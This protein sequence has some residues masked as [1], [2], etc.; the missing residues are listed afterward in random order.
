[1]KMGAKGVRVLLSGRLG[2]AEMSRKYTDRE[3]KIPLQTLRADI[4]YGFTEARTASGHIGVKVWIYR[5][6]VLPQVAAAEPTRAERPATGAPEKPRRGW[7]RVG[8][9]RAEGEGAEE[10]PAAPVEASETIAAP[11]ER[12]QDADAV[13]GQVPEAAAGPTAG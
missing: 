10:A 1:M 7:R 5:G 6:D 13:Q 3:G 2:G 11:E 4:D 12:A 9:R 8:V